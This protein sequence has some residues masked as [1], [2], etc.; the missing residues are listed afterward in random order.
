[1]A[2]KADEFLYNF[3]YI[4]SWILQGIFLYL[5][6]RLGVS[7]LNTDFLLR[8]QTFRSLKKKN[9]DLFLCFCI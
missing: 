6:G 8:C 9:T 1:M 2:W 5:G 3:M 4:M 7:E